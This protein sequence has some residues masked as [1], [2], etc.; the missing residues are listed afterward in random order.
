MSR[1]PNWARFK[2][3]NHNRNSAASTFAVAVVSTVF[4][5]YAAYE[6]HSSVR[7]HGWEG[8]IRYIW[9]GDPYEPKL[10]EYIEILEELEFDLGIY[11]IEDRLCGLEESLD[12]ATSSSLSSSSSS[13]SP[14][15][16]TTPTITING[17]VIEKWNRSWME[18][19]ANSYNN[20]GSGN[21]NGNSSLTVERSLADLSDRLDKIASRVDNIILSS[22]SLN[23]NYLSQKI[24]KRKRILSK[25]IVIDMERCDAILASFQVLK[26]RK[27]PKWP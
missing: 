19:S 13:S 11:R 12:I 17:T 15:S 18:H 9:H 26:T 2:N 10:R 14:S 7:E 1:I 23:D 4:V 5:S 24:K 16:L 22:T 25:A 3:R 21:G 8:T 27:E 6:L 20:N